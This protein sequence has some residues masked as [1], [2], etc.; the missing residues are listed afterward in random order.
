MLN[1]PKK[2]KV[3]EVSARDGLQSFHR[4]VDTDT[5]I[6][7][8]DRLSEVGF[9]VIEVTNFARQTVIPHLKDAEIVMARIQRRPGIV[10]RAQ[11]PN[12][13][14][15]ER[16]VAAKADEI[17]GLITGSETYNLKNQ[18]MTL[19]RGMESAIETFKVAD[20]AGIPYVQAIG[21]AYFCAY[22]GVIPEER[23]LA[24]VKTFANAGITNIYFAGSL[25]NE[26]PRH[27]ASLI[28]KALDQNHAVSI[29]Y[30][31]HNLAG[32]GTANLLAAMDAGASW[33]EGSMCGIGGGIATPTTRGSVG[34]LPTEDIVHFLN[35]MHI[36]T[37]ISSADVL[38]CSRDIA[39]LLDITPLSYLAHCGTRQDIMDNARLHPS[40]L[41]H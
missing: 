38:Q 30:H 16:A 12:A 28:R 41:Q 5:K 39:D 20:K 22:E 25:G 8:V 6:K 17:I 19:E 29:G 32:Y 26:D 31:A 7:M 4:W 10:Y 36:D 37:G 15:A 13:K 11:A 35:D 24:M 33:L 1:I 3:V 23:I 21:M 34:N 40:Q 2:M 18:N 14:G 27:V 9:P